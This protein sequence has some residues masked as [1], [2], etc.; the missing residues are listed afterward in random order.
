[1]RTARILIPLLIIAALIGLSAFPDSGRA[2]PLRNSPGLTNL[3]SWWTLD[4]TSGTRNDS[5]SINHLTDNNTVA[6]T[7]GKKSNA[8]SFVFANSEYLSLAD[9]N[10]LSTGDV[11]FTICSW[12][13]LSDKSREYNFV[14]KWTSTGDQREYRLIYRFA[15]DRLSL[16]ISSTGA[17]ATVATVDNTFSPALNTWYFVCGWHDATANTINIDVN[18]SGTTSLAHSAGVFNSTSSFFLGAVPSASQYHSGLLDETVFYKRVLTTAEREWLYNSGNGRTYSEVIP[19]A[20]PTNT[21]TATNTFTPTATNTSIPPTN[22]FTPTATA[23]N[24]TIPPT[25]TFTPTRTPTRTAT[26][27]FTF[28]PTITNTVPGPTSTFT[29]TPPQTNTPTETATATITLPPTITLTPTITFTPT[30][31]LTPGTM[32]G[33]EWFG[34]I[35]YGDTA[36]VIVTSLLC[37]IIA[38]AFV[39]YLV[40]TNTQRSKRK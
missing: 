26:A 1:M 17:F 11:S 5:H 20:T 6:S 14:S 33:A 40:L 23:T 29:E 21:A 25:N 4:E 9:N 35:T 28:T 27:T 37:L 19:T 7:T 18:T 13:Q 32:P 38:L 10:D 12:I 3:I 36:Q 39:A 30:I 2:A 15:V 34:E 31:T 22:T 16:Q 24:T 8:A